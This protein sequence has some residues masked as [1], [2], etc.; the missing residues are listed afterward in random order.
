M[1]QAANILNHQT[2]R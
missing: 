1:V 2:V